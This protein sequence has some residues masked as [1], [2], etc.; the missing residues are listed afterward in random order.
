MNKFTA[1]C[2]VRSA[3]PWR[4][5]VYCALITVCCALSSCDPKAEDDEEF[6]IVSVPRLAKYYDID[7]KGDTVYK[8]VPVDTFIN[9][10]GQVFSTA[11]LKGNI[12]VVQ[13]FFASCEGICPVISDHMA[14]VQKEFAGNSNV[15]LVSYSVDPAR[16]SAA[17][18][19]AYCKR[20]SCDS[21]QWT[22]VTGDK[23]KIYDLIRYGYQLPD[24]EPGTGGEEDFIHSDQLVLV[25]R[26]SI[27]R[28]YYGG[29]DTAQVR[30]LIEDIHILIN[31]K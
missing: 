14:M 3:H 29:T 12:S 9:Q 11:E 6:A 4:I 17:A 7:E 8:T 31:E 22:L 24:V 23:K 13:L 10:D 28:G 30:M 2:S 21:T 18:L 20:F 16:D 5:I 19:K 26:N 15:N 27:I 1:Q 25:D